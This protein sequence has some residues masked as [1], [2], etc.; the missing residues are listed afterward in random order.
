MTGTANDLPSCGFR[1]HDD[2]SIEWGSS[3]EPGPYANPEPLCVVYHDNKSG[4]WVPFS[5]WVK[6][7][8]GD[9]LEFDCEW[10]AAMSSLYYDDADAGGD[11]ILVG[12]YAKPE[13]LPA[14]IWIAAGVTVRS[15][16]HKQAALSDSDLLAMGYK[17]I[18]GPTPDPFGGADQGGTFYCDA[19]DDNFPDEEASR[20]SICGEDHH[21]HEGDLIVVIDEDEAGLDAAGVYRTLKWPFMM[22]GLIGSGYL[23]EDALVRVA[24]VPHNADLH[25][26]AAGPICRACS[27]T[28]LADRGLKELAAE[29]C[30]DPEAM[31]DDRRE[32]LLDAVRDRVDGWIAG[33]PEWRKSR[34]HEWAGTDLAPRLGITNSTE[35]HS[36]LEEAGYP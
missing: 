2:G 18:R 16:D 20:C 6:D 9:V 5:V 21:M 30:E 36:L 24:D 35:I 1:E 25:Y 26:Y 15:A 8:D 31:P 23:F 17:R 11:S 14:R 10:S 33:Y 3:W 29:W 34:A 13:G 22:Q 19:C 4:A 32:A 28:V 7:D 12:W 27:A